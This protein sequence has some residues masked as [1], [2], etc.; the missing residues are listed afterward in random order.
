MHWSLVSDEKRAHIILKAA[1]RP[2]FPLENEYLFDVELVSNI[3][4]NL[5]GGRAAG[6]DSLVAEHLIYNA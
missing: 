3:M 4:Y 2:I 1:D 5:K 6:L